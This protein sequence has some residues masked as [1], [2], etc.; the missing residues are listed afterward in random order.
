MSDTSLNF[1]TSFNGLSATH[2]NVNIRK[3]V[4]VEAYKHED[5]V[6]LKAVSGH[7]MSS[8]GQS[9]VISQDDFEDI[10]SM[11]CYDSTARA[12]RVLDIL[13]WDAS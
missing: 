9:A 5:G 11:D 2:E 13:G 1:L 8:M 6:L 10:Q 12:I 3:L 7:N 4:S